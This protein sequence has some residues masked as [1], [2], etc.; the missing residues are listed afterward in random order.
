MTMAGGK[1]LEARIVGP[2]AAGSGFKFQSNH[3]DD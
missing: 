2:V 3:A 1:E